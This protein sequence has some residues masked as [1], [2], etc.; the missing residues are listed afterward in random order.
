M[1]LL[2][3]SA[4]HPLHMRCCAW[5]TSVEKRPRDAFVSLSSET[6]KF[7]EILFLTAGGQASDSRRRGSTPAETCPWSLPLEA[8]HADHQHLSGCHSMAAWHVR[9]AEA[10]EKGTHCCIAPT[11]HGASADQCRTCQRGRRASAGGARTAARDRK[12]TRLN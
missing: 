5:Q 7:V 10:A 1:L 4:T 11:D 6:H 12:S 9:E 3:G 2:L 8:G